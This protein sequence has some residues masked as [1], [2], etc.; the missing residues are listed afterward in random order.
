M[1]IPYLLIADISTRRFRRFSFSRATL[2]SDLRNGSGEPASRAQRSNDSW[3]DH[4]GAGLAYLSCARVRDCSAIIVRHAIERQV[5]VVRPV[6]PAAHRSQRAGWVPPRMRASG[7]KVVMLLLA[8]AVMADGFFGPQV[9]P[10]NLAGVLPWI[11]WR[12]FS[13]LALLADRQS[14][15]HGMPVHAAQ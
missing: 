13:V 11:H 4:V 2:V 10:L 14:V 6:R 8:L 5:A 7:R 1:V 12:A 15:L 9:A 3:S